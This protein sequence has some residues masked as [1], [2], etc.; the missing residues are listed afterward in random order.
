MPSVAVIDIGSNS[1]KILVAASA[2]GGGLTLLKTRTIDARISAG[3]SRT[4]PLLAET[5][6]AAGLDAIRTLLADAAPFTPARTLLVAT[7]AVRDAQNGPEFRT[8]V[9]A[10]TGLTI[11]ILT[12]EEEATLIGRGLTCDPALADL[13]DFSVFDLGG[14]SLECLAFR[15]RQVEQAISLPLGC[16]RLTEMF[17]GDAS[18]P[19]TPEA[20]AAIA[21][22]TRAALGDFRFPAP[23]SAAIG[24]GGTLTVARAILAARSGH[25]VEAS[26]AQVTVTELRDLLVWLAALPLPARQQVP[27]LP[28]A[29]ADV[30]PAA[31]ATLI[32]LAET[33]GFDHF[34]HSFYNLRY[35]LAAEALA[36]LPA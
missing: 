29:R 22:H 10:A 17:V 27:G 32:A 12:G 24:T 34:R 14:G 18:Q 33:G 5:G 23:G 20:L 25:G 31:L 13:N 35:G 2:P 21:R 26:Q 36:G 28:A 16:V 11:R 1:I 4:N 6:M 19:I 3:I 15:N 30:M 7:S 8:R 9:Q